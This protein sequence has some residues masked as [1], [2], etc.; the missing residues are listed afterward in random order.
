MRSIERVMASYLHRDVRDDAF[1][2]IVAHYTE[3]AEEQ[4]RE[5]RE[6]ERRA[7]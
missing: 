2:E 3:I 6:A 1:D 5:R 4:R 7:R